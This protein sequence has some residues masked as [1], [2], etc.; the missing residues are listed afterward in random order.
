MQPT[1]E[2]ITARM[3]NGLR[4][5]RSAPALQIRR[6]LPFDNIGFH[7]TKRSEKLLLFSRAYM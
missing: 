4:V 3:F 1:R 5:M 6:P 2:F 7:F